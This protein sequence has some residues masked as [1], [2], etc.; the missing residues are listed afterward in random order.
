VSSLED[1]LGGSSGSAA[2]IVRVG[3]IQ[4]SPAP[5]G[6]TAWVKFVDT[7]PA[8]ELPFI[9]SYV[10]VAGDVVEASFL[11]STGGT[12]QGLILGGK[13]NQSGN[14]VINPNFYRAPILT[15]PPVN[16]PPYHWY[17]YVASG[18]ASIFCQVMRQSVMR[19]IGNISAPGGGLASETY[20]Y[21]SAIPIKAGASYQL[22]AAG[23]ASVF[24]GAALTVQSRVAWF[25]SATDDYPAFKSETQFGTDAL[26]AVTE[27]DIYHY[28]TLTAP[29]GVGFAR[30]V[31]RQNWTGATP[32]GN[33][34]WAEIVM[35]PV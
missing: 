13:A 7:Q 16:A 35:L 6:G 31:M 10:P 9:T 34:M 14:L 4:A 29:A 11:S 25:G 28:G 12:M 18:T 2:P 5:N 21:S 30:V 23:H 17:R 3:T 15:F 32:A 26:G 22:T 24:A 19:F 20:V 1:Q 8:V 33:M 27:T